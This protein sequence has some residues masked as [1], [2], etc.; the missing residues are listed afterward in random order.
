M[1]KKL[2]YLTNSQQVF[3]NNKSAVR[4]ILNKI[5]GLLY[6]SDLARPLH[7]L[8]HE[9]LGTHA[10]HE[11]DARR[12]I[13]MPDFFRSKD[14][15]R[16]LV[17]AAAAVMTSATFLVAAAGPAVAASPHVMNSVNSMPNSNIVRGG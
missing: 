3:R 9:R 14:L 4:F 11:P 8:W 15:L 2:V 16:S 1:A 6:F 12:T 10:G 5:S 7:C 17:A 13:M